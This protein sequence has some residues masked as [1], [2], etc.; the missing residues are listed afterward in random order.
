MIKATITTPNDAYTYTID[1][2]DQDEQ[3]VLAQLQEAMDEPSSRDFDIEFEIEAPI[4]F[5]TFLRDVVGY[6]LDDGEFQTLWPKAHGMVAAS[7]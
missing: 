2:G 3:E 5:L 6:G 4:P 1:P 7:R